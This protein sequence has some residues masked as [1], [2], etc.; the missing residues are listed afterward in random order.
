[1][2]SGTDAEQPAAP[3]VS[4]DTAPERYRHWQLDVEAVVPL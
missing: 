1:M 3:I 4:F 2:T